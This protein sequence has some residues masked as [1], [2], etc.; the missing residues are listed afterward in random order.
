V[1]PLVADLRR[2]SPEFEAM[3]R[4]HDVPGAHGDA[5]KHLQHPVLGPVALEYSAFAVDGRTDL[6]LLVYNGAT[7]EDA[8]R[9]A[10]LVEG[11]EAG[12]AKGESGARPAPG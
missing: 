11:R 2:L 5:V 7:P 4:D 6:S 9:I 12:M 10:A 3:W 1:E 8:A